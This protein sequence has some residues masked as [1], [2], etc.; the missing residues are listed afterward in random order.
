MSIPHIL[1]VAIILSACLAGGLAVL[2]RIALER[3]RLVKRYDHIK[4]VMEYEEQLKVHQRKMQSSIAH[5]DY[6]VAQPEADSQTNGVP[7]PPRTT[8]DQP[9]RTADQAA[10]DAEPTAVATPVEP[11]AIPVAPAAEAIETVG[12]A[13]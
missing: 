12:P 1:V 2:L 9:R 11:S 10:G 5:E 7:V 4:A 3:E 8:A 13:G 6:F